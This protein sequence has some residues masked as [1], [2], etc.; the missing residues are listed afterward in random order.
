MVNYIFDYYESPALYYNGE[1]FIKNL[2]NHEIKKTFTGRNEKN[3]W[4][5][6]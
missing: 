1:S 4:R 3:Y 5:H 6:T 2:I